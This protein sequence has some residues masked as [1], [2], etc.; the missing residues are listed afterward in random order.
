[1]RCVVPD[2]FQ[3]FSLG[4]V[5]KIIYLSNVVVSHNMILTSDLMDSE[6]LLTSGL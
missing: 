1:M 3:I 2:K 6:C 4:L 5:N